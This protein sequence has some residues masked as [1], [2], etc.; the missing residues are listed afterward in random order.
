MGLQPHLISECSI[1]LHCFAIEMLMHGHIITITCNNIITSVGS[2]I[3]TSVHA[4][5][6][7]CMYVCT[8]T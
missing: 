4:I 1:G 5:V 2:Y 6:I 7:A 3:I 8:C